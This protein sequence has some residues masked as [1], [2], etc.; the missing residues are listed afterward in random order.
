[1]GIK[2]TCKITSYRTRPELLV[3]LLLT[4]IVVAVYYQVRNHEFVHYD[5]YTY[6][7]KNPHIQS[8][9]NWKGISWAFTATR[10]GNWHPLTWLSHMLDLSLY[11]MNAGGHHLTNVVFHILNTLLLFMLFSKM[12]GDVWK[13]SFIAALFAL[14]PLHVESVAW[15]SERKDV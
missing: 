1:M 2:K 10:A 6:V 5:D 11:G 3:C 9:L 4:L 14:H 12:T 15:V 8:G 13:C 7:A